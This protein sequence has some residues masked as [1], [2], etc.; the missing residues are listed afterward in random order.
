MLVRKLLFTSE[1][2]NELWLKR[3]SNDLMG[4]VSVDNKIVTRDGWN[5]YDYLL[6]ED[7]DYYYTSC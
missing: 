2:V 4:D 7:G 6:C 5:D 3:Y 1:L